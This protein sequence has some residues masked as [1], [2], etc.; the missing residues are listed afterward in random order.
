[1]NVRLVG[2]ARSNVVLESDDVRLQGSVVGCLFVV[3][4]MQCVPD[5]DKLS[6]QYGRSGAGG[7][8]GSGGVAAGQGGT[9]SGGTTN[10]G[11]G[12]SSGTGGDTGDGGTTAGASDAG[13]G[14]EAGQ[15]GS[16]QGGETT[17]GS[18]GT[19]GKGG[20]G[21][22]STSGGHGGTTSAGG[23]PSSGGMSSGGMSGGMS[24]G[25]TIGESGAAGAGPALPCVDG[26]ALVYIPP[27]ANFSQ[28]YT[29]NLDLNA[30]VDLSDSV[31]TAHIRAIDFTGGSDNIQ[32]YAS[33]TGFSFYG[34]NGATLP[35]SSLADGG[36]LTMD[37]TSTGTW[38]AKHTI[39]FGFLLHGSSVASTVQVLVED[40]MIAVKADPM[41]MTKVG[42]WLFT[43][44]SDVNEA[45]AET[46]PGTYSDQNIIFANPYMAVAGAKAIW[47]P[48]GP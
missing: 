6:S 4:C 34:N 17:G 37:L 48:P 39:S 25:G 24:T 42:P 43:K 2:T 28:F 32:L 18:G 38:D 1:M 22:S 41:A 10:G 19:G 9:F 36:V 30:G 23:T 8:A 13:Q 27:L 12:A 7:M 5:L 47:V 31:I 44:K 26:C 29:I 20:K 33:A 45:S 14:G 46:I 35:L 11:K 21:G 40:V 16:S 15:S 3:L